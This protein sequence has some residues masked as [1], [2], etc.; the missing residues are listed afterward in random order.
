MSKPTL[1]LDVRVWATG[2]FWHRPRALFAAWAR[3]N[4]RLAK[5]LTTGDAVAFRSLT[6]NQVALCWSPEWKGDK[7]VGLISTLFSW[8]DNLTPELLVTIAA[9]RR[10][11]IRQ[12]QSY[13]EAFARAQKKK[14][15]RRE[16]S[17]RP[18]D[19]PPFFVLV[20]NP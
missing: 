16:H 13:E 8:D 11:H 4:L 2:P 20:E 12:L 15:L 18:A 10:I 5:R 3:A 6:G 14:A 9:K 1:S 7:L 17:T 19:E